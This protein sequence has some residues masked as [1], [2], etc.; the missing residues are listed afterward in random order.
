LL[1]IG[2]TKAGHKCLINEL[3]VAQQEVQPHLRVVDS[4][5]AV[6][7]LLELVDL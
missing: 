4:A 7:A 5:V 1:G 6:A 2:W 3:L